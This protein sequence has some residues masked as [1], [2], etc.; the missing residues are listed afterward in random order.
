MRPPAVD[1][2]FEVAFWLLDRAL[3]DGEY[4]QPQKMHR[5]MF[6]CFAYFAAAHHGRKLMPA[7]F[8]ASADGPLEPNIY[9]AFENDRP[10]LNIKPLKDEAL[11]VCDSVWRR[12]GH[13]SVEKLNKALKSHPPYEAAF[14]EG[15]KSEITF[16]AI[17]AFYGDA[18][19][20]GEVRP[21]DAPAVENVL[22][23]KVMRS[24]DG[25]PV[26]VTKWSVKKLDGV[27]P[28]NRS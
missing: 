19:G 4:L 8:V 12:F 3:D 1:S 21:S 2:C 22:R 17:L 7:T 23:P 25:K 26:S 6:L 10:F 24:Q 27:K 14:N 18:F 5:I 16:D 9:K 11:E 15:P 28:A 13:H 20:D